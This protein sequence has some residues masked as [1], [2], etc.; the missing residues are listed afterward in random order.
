MSFKV[1]ILGSSSAQPTP[2]RHHSAH[3]LNVHEQFYLVDCGESAQRQLMKYGINPMKINVVFITHLHGDHLFGL[4][5][6][7]STLSLMGRRIP[8]KIFAPAPMKEI[9]EFNNRHFN[10]EPLFE[11]QLTEVDTR[12]HNLIYE[13]KVMEVWTVPL[14][15][16]VPCCGYHFREKMPALNVDKEKIEQ[17][18]LEIA[19]IVAAKRG[20]D[21][22]TDDGMVIPNGELTYRP[23][24]PRSYAYL[25]DTLFSAKAAGLVKGVDLLYHEATFA[26][27]DKVL[28]RQTGHS[29][30]SQAA[31]AAMQS[32][33]KRLVIG[34]FSGRYKDET[35][36]LDEARQ[37]FPGTE[38]AAEGATFEIPMQK[39]G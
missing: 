17:Y 29:T 16:R 22:V 5:P 15:H 11:T 30:A 23:Y 10:R 14:R 2:H 26:D 7:L 1:T 39:H 18:G 6:L 3:A 25:S 8:L 36:L 20:D 21:V 12:S 24:S 32:E 27:T 13:N 19:Q 9:L 31:K 4:F 35:V 38:L 33:A 37:I 28:A 34:H